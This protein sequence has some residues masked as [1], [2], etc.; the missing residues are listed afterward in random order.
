MAYKVNTFGSSNSGFVFERIKQDH[1]ITEFACILLIIMT[2]S[3]D[4][5]A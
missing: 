2:H 1:I 3:V 4:V 5:G